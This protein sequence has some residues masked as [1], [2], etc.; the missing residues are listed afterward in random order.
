MSHDFHTLKVNKIRQETKASKTIFFAV[1]PDL[2]AAYSYKPGQYLTLKFIMN[3]KEVRRAYSICA[4]PSEPALAVNVKRLKGG[5]VSNHINE[6]LREGDEIEVMQPDGNFTVAA[7]SAKRRDLYFFAAGSGI[8]PI[9]SLVKTFLEEEPKSCCYLCFGNRNEDQIIFNDQLEALEKKYEN[10]FFLKHTLSKPKREKEKGLKAMFSRGKISWEGWTGRIDR[11][12]VDKFL[13]LYPARGK[14]A[15]Y[16]VCGPGAMIDTV[17]DQLSSKGIQKEFIHREYFLSSVSGSPEGVTSGEASSVKV[18][19][20]GKEIQ[21]LVPPEK[22]ILDV[23]IEEKYDPPYSCTSGACSTCVAKLL[24][25]KVEMDAC[26]A[27]DDDEVDA[28]YILVCQSRARTPVV[29][30]RFES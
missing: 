17:V 16:F 6:H 4:A 27:L 8:T 1:P 14:E 10:Q 20:A 19:L 29:E 15:H 7:D 30:L 23:L 13:G 9:M 2:A 24:N 5:L 21:V 28:G 22:T 12:M 3:G 26:Y 25:G 18:H 11:A